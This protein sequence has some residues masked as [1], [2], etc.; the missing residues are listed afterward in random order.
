VAS[1]TLR[2]A[3]RGDARRAPENS[4]AALLAAAANP[5]CDGLEFDVRRSSD[6]VPILLHD[7][8]LERVQGRPE[9][10]ADLT[11]DQLGDLG[12]PTLA[13]VLA[14]VPRRAFLDVELKED[15]GRAAVEVLA[16]GRGAE[17]RHA[18]VSSFSTAALERVGG[19]ASTWPRWLNS[20]DL[21]PTTIAT[22][23]EL[24]C[25][26]IAAAWRAIDPGSAA[27]VRAADLVLAAFTVRR[28]PTFD[29]LARLGALAV[30]VEAAALDGDATDAA[31]APVRATRR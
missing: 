13:D 25:V 29:R 31:G 27:R 12:I 9:R 16:S 21:E 19:L 1:T 5:A 28:R 4:L 7:A 3:H 8:T 10:A 22:A 17:L 2:L 18:V 30:C 20:H 6:G 14:A 24:G 15:T 23:V 11:A 26:G